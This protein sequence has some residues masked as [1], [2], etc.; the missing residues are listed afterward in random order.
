MSHPSWKQA[1]ETE[2]ASTD[3]QGKDRTKPTTNIWEKPTSWN[4]G[5]VIQEIKLTHKEMFNRTA[6][7]M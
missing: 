3:K 1:M 2:K 5:K 6:L 7:N 4:R